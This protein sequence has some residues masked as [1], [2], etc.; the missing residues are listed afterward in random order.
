MLTL[1]EADDWHLGVHHLFS[2]LIHVL[3]CFH[4]KEV[5]KQYYSENLDVITP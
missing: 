1:F 2:M 3:E 4:N 5:R